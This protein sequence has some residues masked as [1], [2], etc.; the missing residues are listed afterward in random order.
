MHI[1]YVLYA[2]LYTFKYFMRRTGIPQNLLYN[3]ARKYVIK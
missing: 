1:L 3:I 2:R